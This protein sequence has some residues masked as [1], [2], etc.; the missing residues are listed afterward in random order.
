MSLF[1]FFV[2]L[3]GKQSSDTAP[4]KNVFDHYFFDLKYYLQK[5]ASIKYFSHLLNVRAE[6]VDEISTIYYMLP[7]Q[8]LVNEYR[9]KHFVEEIE[10]PIN[11]NL[12][13]E[14]IINL[15]GFNSNDNFV[16]Y[17][18]E[19]RRINQLQEKKIDNYLKYTS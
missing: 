8:L 13:I 12:S 18:K 7:F 4:V 15:C 9:Y 16:E 19:K 14:S 6:K 2:G 10:N 11:A 5:D 1:N 17:V 3:T